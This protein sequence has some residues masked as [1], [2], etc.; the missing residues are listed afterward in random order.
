MTPYYDTLLVR[1]QA[2]LAAWLRF[3]RARQGSE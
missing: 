3:Q 1:E 2:A